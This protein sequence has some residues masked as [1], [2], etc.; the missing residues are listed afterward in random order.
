MS[1]PALEVVAAVAKNGVIGREGQLPWHLPDDLKQFKSLTLGHPILMGR[2]T[3]ESIGRALPGRRSIVISRSPSFALPD[4]VEHA[5][6]LDSAIEM[7]SKPT[8]GTQGAAMIIGGGV[9]YAATLPRASVLHLTELDD[10][11]EG[12][13][14]FPSYDKSQWVLRHER[15]HERDER[16]AMGFY[17]RT[18]DR[19]S[20]ALP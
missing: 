1:A 13:A 3:F 9:L 12:D 11:V 20:L 18:Y 17:F 16:H 4:G 10:P 5:T 6:S 7:A 8:G 15:R 14:I 2:R 19:L